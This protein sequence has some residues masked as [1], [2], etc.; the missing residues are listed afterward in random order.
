MR[1]D[2]NRIEGGGAGG[3]QARERKRKEEENVRR[4]TVTVKVWF[5]LT[6]NWFLWCA[7]L[8]DQRSKVRKGGE[9]VGDITNTTKGLL[10][11]SSIWYLLYQLIL[12]WPGSSTPT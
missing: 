3:T 10:E 4:E 1:S 9:C 7:K 12:L 11:K 5:I 6:S 2:E 8:R